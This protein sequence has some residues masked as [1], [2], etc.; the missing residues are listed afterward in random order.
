MTQRSF[1]LFILLALLLF[2]QEASTLQAQDIRYMQ[3]HLSPLQTN[4]AMVGAENQKQ[5]I[6][7]YQQYNVGTGAAFVSPTA[8][9]L[10]P[11]IRYNEAKK[12]SYRWG[13]VGFG[14]ISDQTGQNG[15][16][17]TNGITGALAINF[18]IPLPDG[19]AV[20]EDS[21]LSIGAQASY[22]MRGINTAAITTGRQFQFGRVDPT[23]P[24]GEQFDNERAMFPL[25]NAG[26]FW[27]TQDRFQEQMTTFIGFSVSNINQPQVA[28]IGF[29]Q[30]NELGVD[31]LPMM[32]SAT[33]GVS[34]F[35]TGLVSV[36]PNARWI[37]QGG[38][39][40][41]SAGSLFRIQPQSGKLLDKKFNL[42]AWYNTLTANASVSTEV[43]M[44]MWN[45]KRKDNSGGDMFI[46][47]AYDLPS[48]DQGLRIPNGNRWEITVGLKFGRRKII[49]DKPIEIKPPTDEDRLAAIKPDTTGGND[50]NDG[51]GDNN[52]IRELLSDKDL[53]LFNYRGYFSYLTDTVNT[54]T[55][56]LLDEIAEIMRKYPTLRIEISGHS[57]SLTKDERENAQLSLRRAKAGKEY[58]VKRGVAPNRIETASYGANQPIASNDTEFGR[59]KNRRID[60]RI[61]NP[62]FQNPAKKQEAPKEEDK[63]KGDQD[64]DGENDE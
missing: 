19:L 60:F 26:V 42:G 15:I 55:A 37:S 31:R 6:L 11:L 39:N 49:L 48:F 64:D 17:Q 4:P 2:G 16:L 61:L 29:G 44:P 46:A 14:V 33:A 10:L 54:T 45:D 47:L 62:E 36:M 21:Y 5:F 28:I 23:L 20:V 38:A 59:I 24:T 12:A 50:G 53:E 32:L 1:F 58:L 9:I 35:K 25:F 56:E 43:H 40:Q 13:G 8:S 51:K 27:Y 57:C 3:Y 7:N 52:S 18:P 22:F 34:F 63:P 30:Q 41:I